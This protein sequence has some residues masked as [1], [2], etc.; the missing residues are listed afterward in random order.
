MDFL[1]TLDKQMVKGLQDWIKEF[2]DLAGWQALDP[3][4]KA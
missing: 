1:K 4:I 3:N 2:K